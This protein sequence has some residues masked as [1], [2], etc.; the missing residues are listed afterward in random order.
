MSKNTYYFSPDD[1][2]FGDEQVEQFVMVY[3]ANDNKIGAIKRQEG[4][5][6]WIWIATRDYRDPFPFRVLDADLTTS[7]QLVHKMLTI[8]V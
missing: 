2:R 8:E 4:K 5:P 1:I 7:Q 6:N 3:D